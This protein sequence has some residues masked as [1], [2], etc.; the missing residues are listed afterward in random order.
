MKATLKLSTSETRRTSTIITNE[1]KPFARVYSGDDTSRDIIKAC[2][3]AAVGHV[4]N[5]LEIWRAM[6]EHA[7]NLTISHRIGGQ[8][9]LYELC[10][11]M[12]EA[13]SD[14][15]AEAGPTRW[16]DSPNDWETTATLFVDLIFASIIER[17]GN[18]PAY[19]ALFNHARTKGA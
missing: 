2:N 16:E 19:S 14:W 18:T 10:E 11:A 17:N 6:D 1:G 12:A 7:D 15:E 9:G 5:A 3:R 8:F 4:T 13:V